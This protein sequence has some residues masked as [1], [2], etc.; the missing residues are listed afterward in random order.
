MLITLSI[1]IRLIGL[2]AEGFWYDEVFTSVL[3]DLPLPRMLA[4]TAGDVHPPLI[5]VLS[6]LVARFANTEWSL[7]LVP[8]IAGALAVGESYRLTEHAAGKKI[9]AAAGLLV[10]LSPAQIH[11][12]QEARGYTLLTL[13]V[14][15]AANSL[16]ERRWTRFGLACALAMYTHNMAAIYM[17][18][19]APFALI[20]RST[21]K[22]AARAIALAIACWL[23]WLP[24]LLRQLSAVDAG[25]WIV[26]QGLGGLLYAWHYAIWGYRQW[27][28]LNA[29]TLALS[30]GLAAISL[31][32]IKRHNLKKIGILY[33]LTFAPAASLGILSAAW[34]PMLLQRA[35]VP[36]GAAAIP[37]ATAAISTL[38]KRQRRIALLLILPAL[39]GNLSAHWLNPFT[40]KDAQGVRNLDHIVEHAQPC[41]AVYHN[42]AG[43]YLFALRALPDLPHYMLP[44]P[45]SLAVGLSAATSDAIG[46]RSAS[47]EEVSTAGHCRIWYMASITPVGSHYQIPARDHILATY[48]I[49]GAWLLYDQGWGEITLYE[50]E[51]D[52]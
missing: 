32:T 29:H 1:G 4:A 40:A 38:T 7:R 2:G 22:Q 9:A 46:V 39:A 35:L 42:E 31:L 28:I 12:S 45:D 27:E 14:L 47:I 11:Y 48:P 8:A 16:I 3:A 25:F 34:Q 6:W 19:L 26:D 21:R 23:P 43:S 13:F 50:I 49:A 30:G 15:L 37:L 44:A 51:A 41:D 24:F 5:Y 52:S 18:T 10:A 20:P 33:A 36:A 17:I